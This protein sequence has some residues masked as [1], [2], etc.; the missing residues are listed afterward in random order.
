MSLP[1]FG[2]EAALSRTL[3]VYNLAWKLDRWGSGVIPQQP[4]CDQTCI[5]ACEISCP[6]AGDCPD[7]P[8]APPALRAECLAGARA[9]RNACRKQ[10]CTTCT[11]TCGPC[12]GGTCNAYP[13][14]GPVPMSGT[15]TCTDCNGNQTTRPC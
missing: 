8:P 7:S 11:V 1:G 2:A 13:N 10:C 6:D 5:D 9:C 15:Q 12:S 14:C 3:L 4:Q